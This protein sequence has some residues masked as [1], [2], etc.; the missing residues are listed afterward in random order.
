MG[1]KIEIEFPEVETKVLATLLEKE[2]PERCNAL[3]NVLKKPIKMFCHHTLSTGQYFGADGRPPRHPVKMGTQAAP[4]GKKTRLLCQLDPGMIAYPGGHSLRFAYGPDIT[5]PLASSGPVVAK[6]D[7]ECLDDLMK[8]GM[9]IWNAQYMTHRL[10]TIIVRRK[11][12]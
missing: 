10:A 11:E 4:I 9:S 12:G 5:E 6:V 7:K 1:R 2:E 3:W 8:C